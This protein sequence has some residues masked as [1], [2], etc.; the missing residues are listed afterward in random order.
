MNYI[1]NEKKMSDVINYE[2]VK[3]LGLMVIIFITLV[4][5]GRVKPEKL[6]T[7]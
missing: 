7:A 2:I 4:Y 1:N 5:F 6:N 3:N